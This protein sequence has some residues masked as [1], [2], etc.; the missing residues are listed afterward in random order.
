MKSWTLKTSLSDFKAEFSADPTGILKTITVGTQNK[1]IGKIVGY[2]L[3]YFCKCNTIL[4]RGISCDYYD[5]SY[6]QPYLH[7]Q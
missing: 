7:F 4:G 1:I 5:L 3:T 2:F 6:S